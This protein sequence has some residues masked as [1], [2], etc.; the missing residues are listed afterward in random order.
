MNLFSLGG[1]ALLPEPLSRGQQKQPLSNS[2]NPFG[3][4]DRLGGA[5]SSAPGR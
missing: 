4:R 1:H 2:Y 5:E 3:L